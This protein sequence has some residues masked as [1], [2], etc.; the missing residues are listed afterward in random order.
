VP[1][2]IHRHECGKP[3]HQREPWLLVSAVNLRDEARPVVAA[4]DSNE[5]R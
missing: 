3:E 5:H 1:L 4:I 2:A